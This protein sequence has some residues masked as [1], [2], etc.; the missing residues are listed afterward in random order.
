PQTHVQGYLCS[1][2]AT[3]TD[4]LQD[5]GRKVQ[6]RSGSRYRAALAGEH[7][8]IALPVCLNVGARNIGRQRNVADFS[9]HSKKVIHRCEPQSSLPELAASDH[10]GLKRLAEMNLFTDANFSSRPDQHLP[11]PE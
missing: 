5:L 6:S 9:Q 11:L 7:R 4:A 3:G 8:L 10:L 2:N 1:F